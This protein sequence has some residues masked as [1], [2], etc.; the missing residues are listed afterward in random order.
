VDTH[1][2]YAVLNGLVLNSEFPTVET[3]TLKAF[4]DNAS[5]LLPTVETLTLKAFADN[6]SDLLLVTENHGRW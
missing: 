2:L 5:D 4:A 6:A 3:L 1:S